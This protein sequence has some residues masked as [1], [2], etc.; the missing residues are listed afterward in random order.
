[1]GPSAAN[2]CFMNFARFSDLVSDEDVRKLIEGQENQNTKKNT[3]W[4]VGVFEKWRTYR[5]NM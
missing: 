4:A 5:I 3:K 1:M 2:G